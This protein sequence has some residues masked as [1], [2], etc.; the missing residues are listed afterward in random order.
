MN[1]SKARVVLHES[2]SLDSVEGFLFSWPT[3]D[4]Q[5]F[6]IFSGDK[7]RLERTSETGF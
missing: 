6:A 2:N 5:K 4:L 1:L 3:L 7:I